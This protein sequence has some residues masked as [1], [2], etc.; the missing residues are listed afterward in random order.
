MPHENPIEIPPSP[1]DIA[2]ATLL[3]EIIDAPKNEISVDDDEN[4]TGPGRMKAEY[5]GHTIVVERYQYEGGDDYFAFIDGNRR[6]LHPA[7]MLNEELEK[8]F[9]KLMSV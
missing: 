1:E 5:K 6:T 7:V 3:R 8:V 4:E 9:N 2:N